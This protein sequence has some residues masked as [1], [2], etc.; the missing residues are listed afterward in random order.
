MSGCA[1]DLPQNANELLRIR[2]AGENASAARQ[3]T[4]TL[5][6]LKRRSI[7]IRVMANV[8]E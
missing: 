8:C 6:E 4:H 5:T 1:S 3:G 2:R 7:T